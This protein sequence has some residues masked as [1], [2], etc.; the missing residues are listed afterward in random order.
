MTA[1]IVIADLD[2]ELSA[3][4]CYDSVSGMPVGCL[5]GI[6]RPWIRPEGVGEVASLVTIEE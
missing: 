6:I 4:G 5:H 2:V 1:E 3:I